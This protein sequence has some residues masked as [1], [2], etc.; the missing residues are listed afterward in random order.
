M[1]NV[2]SSWTVD[3]CHRITLQEGSQIMNAQPNALAPSN[4]P[5]DNRRTP[6]K[7][8]QTAVPLEDLLAHYHSQLDAYNAAALVAPASAAAVQMSRFDDDE[9]LPTK[10]A[11]IELI[12]KQNYR[13]GRFI[14]HRSIE[15]LQSI[16]KTNEEGRTVGYSYAE[17]LDLLAVEFPEAS[18]SAACLR[19][20][21]VHLWS[22]ADEEGL[23]RPKMPQLRPRSVKRKPEAAD[24]A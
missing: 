22:E 7:P 10:E 5:A 2:T 11:V 24:A 3:V 4:S 13:L 15:L 17:I 20:Y 1:T 9:N 18:T 21:V 19:W 14:R 8:V 23:P 16:V 12:R 6:S